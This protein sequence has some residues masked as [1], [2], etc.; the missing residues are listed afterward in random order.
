MRMRAKSLVV[1]CALCS[2]VAV[3]VRAD[4]EKTEDGCRTVERTVMVPTWVTETR[5]V[6]VTEYRQVQR[7]CKFIVNEMVPHIEKKTCNFTVYER[8]IQ[9][10][11]ITRMVRRR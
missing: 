6:S 3:T 9:K 5:K 8:Q 1:A 11:E 4:D 10:H 2:A 7:E